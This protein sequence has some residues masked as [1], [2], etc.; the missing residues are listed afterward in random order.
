MKKRITEVEESNEIATLALT[1]TKTNIRRLRL[2][3]AI[4]IERLEQR[5]TVPAFDPEDMSPP[6]S[7]KILD[8]SLSNNSLKQSKNGSGAAKRGGR[9]IGGRA[10]SSTNGSTGSTAKVRDP[11]LPKRPTNAY[12]IFCDM[13]KDRIRQEIED[14]NPGAAVTELSKTITEAWNNLD[15]EGRAPYFRLYQDDRERYHR[16]MSV[17]NQRKQEAG[18]PLAPVPKRQKIVFKI[19]EPQEFQKVEGKPE[20]DTD[21]KSELNSEID[22]PSELNEVDESV[23]DIPDSEANPVDDTPFENQQK[24]DEKKESVPE[25]PVKKP[26]S[27]ASKGEPMEE[28]ATVPTDLV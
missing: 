8:E 2:E 10:G 17:Y 27:E 9:K 12:L 7:P 4:L 26:E 14:K 13:E 15:E 3:Y 21:I 25:E 19:K 20:T 23:A 24:E 5:A 11:D 22:P 1:R 18:E 6:P 28:N 16:E